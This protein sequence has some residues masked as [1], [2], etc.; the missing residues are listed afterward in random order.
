MYTYFRFQVL[1]KMLFIPNLP[2]DDRLKSCI[3]LV[4]SMFFGNL[5]KYLIFDQLIHTDIFCYVRVV[6]LCFVTIISRLIFQL[7]IQHRLNI[8][9]SRFL[10]FLLQA[11]L[12]FMALLCGLSRIHDNKH[13]PGDV[14]AGFLVGTIVANAVV[15]YVGLTSPRICLPCPSLCCLCLL[16]AR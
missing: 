11:G 16:C 9:F 7:Y 3:S 6:I 8:G 2:F 10:K 14:T 1:E 4:T 5:E 15:S 13:H 12:V